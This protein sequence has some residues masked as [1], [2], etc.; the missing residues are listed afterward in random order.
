[1]LLQKHVTFLD[2]L[3]SCK[4]MWST[5]EHA[6]N[7]HFRGSDNWTE[8]QKNDFTEITKTDYLNNVCG[9]DIITLLIL[10]EG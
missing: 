5:Y 3:I 10:Q 8:A 9:L 1:M 6:F 2:K 4:N 7:I